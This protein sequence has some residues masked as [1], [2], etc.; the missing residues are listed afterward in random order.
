MSSQ[1]VMFRQR[2]K[3]RVHLET[4]PGFYRFSF[5]PFCSQKSFKISKFNWIHMNR[6]LGLLGLW[7]FSNSH[8]VQSASR[9]SPLSSVL[10]SDVNLYPGN[11]PHDEEQLQGA[12]TAPYVCRDG[13]AHFWQVNINAHFWQINILC[14]ITNIAILFYT[15]LSPMSPI[16][17]MTI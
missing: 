5:C 8:G 4:L 15:F 9:S 13:Y 3:K 7:G 11:C 2:R 1:S 14:S 17:N 10:I 12:R 16:L 6:C